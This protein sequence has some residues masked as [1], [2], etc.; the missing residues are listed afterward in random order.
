MPE[1]PE[2]ETVRRGL[3]PVMAGR[4]IVRAEARRPDLRFPLPAR[5]S[6]RLDG[7]RIEAVDRRA[8][9][10]VLPLDTGEALI[11]HMGMSGRF[12][13]VE[14]GIARGFGDYVYDTGAD[15]KHD[16]VLLHLE[17][18]R[19]VVFNDPRRFG[20]MD[21]VA[22][23]RT[24]ACAHFVRMGPEP[25]GNG[26]DAAVL[27]AA[28]AGRRTAIKPALL[29]QRIVAGLGNIYVCEALFRARVSPMRPAGALTP[30]ETER[31]VAAIRDVL[32]EAIEAGGSTLRDFAAADGTLGGFQERFDVY[33]R[34]GEP[35]HCGAAHGTVERFVQGGRSTFHCPACQT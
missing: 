8:K 16:H 30:S 13:V 31:L 26:F 28:L 24:D 4:R 10:L 7:A 2:V 32:T 15:P 1:L 35:C 11:M 19:A 27:G 21:L 14:G 23:A 22:A 6:A 34:E 18:G 20:Y 5:F 29:D 33:D 25:L 12:S 17:D 3:S 9:Y